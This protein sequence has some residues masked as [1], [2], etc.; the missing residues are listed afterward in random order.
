[1][2]DIFDIDLQK[3][4]VNG[5]IYALKYIENLGYD[6]FRLM[7]LNGS[8]MKLYKYY[9]NIIKQG[10]N[11]S[12]EALENNTIYLNDSAYFDDCFDCRIDM[13]EEKFHFLQL[14]DYC[15][16]FKIPISDETTQE[17]ANKL[18]DFISL[19]D[20]NI[21]VKSLIRT[22]A[23]EVE[24]LFSEVFFKNV[25]VEYNK[26]GDWNQAIFNVIHKDYQRFREILKPFKISCFSSSPYLNRMWSSS[27]GNNNEGFC[28]EYTIDINS[29]NEYQKSYLNLFPVI[30]STARLESYKLYPCYKIDFE[31]NNFWQLFFNG[32]LRKSADWVD[33][34][35]WR[36]ILHNKAIE[37]NY[38]GT[39]PIPFFKISK[40]FLGNRMSKRNREKIISICKKNNIDYVGLIRDDNSFNLKVCE[41]DC[42]TCL[43]FLEDDLFIKYLQQKDNELIKRALTD[44]SYKK[45]FQQKEKAEFKGKT[46]EE[47]A[48]LGDSLLKT[49][50]CARYLDEKTHLSKSIEPYITDKVLVEVIAK[51]Y[52]LIKFIDFDINDS[53]IPKN[54]E[55]SENEETHKYIATAVEAVLGAIYLRNN[56][57]EELQEIIENWI[58]MIEEYSYEKS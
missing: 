14:R 18:S 48:T 4:I 43:S 49:I 51:K 20:Q 31:S 58:N 25:H 28:I 6:N 39:N 50:L 32:L 7:H 30:Y 41:K 54:Y 8:I 34:M 33:Q 36:L 40:V 29:Q 12:L 16:Y 1:M 3:C 35:E 53:L 11:Y 56:S 42:H 5:K 9:P 57:L 21:D 26:K 17:L 15:N 10:R 46:N 55:Y 38:N 13:N 2:K 24:R 19:F 37:E 44:T 27:Y 22:D 45:F 47:L 23:T 52:D